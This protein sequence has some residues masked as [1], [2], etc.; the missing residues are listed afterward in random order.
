MTGT[1]VSNRVKFK[2]ILFEYPLI[3]Q[4]TSGCGLACSTGMN[5]MAPSLS[6]Q[7]SDTKDT[8]AACSAFVRRPQGSE[9]DRGVP[10]G[11]LESCAEL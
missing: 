5:Q 6:T 9:G 7:K 11:E 1:L 2:C 4:M 10:G 3:G 8:R